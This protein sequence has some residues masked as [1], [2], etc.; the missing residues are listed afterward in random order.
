MYVLIVGRGLRDG[1]QLD[2]SLA[3][4]GLDWELEW[5]EDIATAQAVMA[6]RQIDVLAA[7][8]GND[9]RGLALL[10]EARS[11][12]SSAARLVL[13]PFGADATPGVLDAAHRQL[14]LP[15]QAEQ[16]VEAIEGITELR[17]LLDAPALVDAIGKVGHLPPAPETYLAISRALGDPHSTAAKIGVMIQAD[18]ALVAKVLRVCNSAYF[19]GGR[20]ISDVR[21]A[22]LRLGIDTLRRI[23][24]AAEV[25]GGDGK[26]ASGV[27]R[28]AIRQRAFIASQIAVKLM[29]GPSA[30]LAGTAALLAEIGRLL[31]GFDEADGLD[32]QPGYAEAGAYLMGLWGLPMPIVEGV[33]LHRQPAR[34]RQRGLWVPGVVH[35]AHALAGG[36]PLD[37]AW[38]DATGLRERL[39]DWQKIADA[40]IHAGND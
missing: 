16:L 31:P 4:L 23:V 36:Y 6:E 22:V 15:L 17:E 34:S 27:D 12:Q 39:P 9:G 7:E 18:P 2:A 26:A 37:D 11:K 40:I 29:P 5:A 8:V 38:V 35:V 21:A 1:S 30:D 32:G 10:R 28:G 24:L 3:D 14:Q 33:A 25:M 19:S 13:I 20:E